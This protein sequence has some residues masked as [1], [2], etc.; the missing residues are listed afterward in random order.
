MSQMREAARSLDELIA[1]PIEPENQGLAITQLEG[2]L[3]FCDVSF[4]YPQSDRPA[5]DHISF[6]A[7]PGS[8]LAFVGPSGCGK[9]TILS[10][11]LGF[12]RPTS[13]RILLDGQDLTTLKL[14]DYR[15]QIGV[16]TQDTLLL[17][18]T[19][20]ENVAYGLPDVSDD[21]IVEALKQAE[22]YDFVCQLPEGLQ[23]KIGDE[24]QKLSGGQK[25]RLAL[26]RA[27]LRN[28]KILIL[29]EATSAIDV[30]IEERLQDT[31][32]RVMRGRTTFIVSHRAPSIIHCDTILVLDKGQVTA[33]GKH[34]ELLGSSS[35]YR[36]LAGYFQNTL[37]NA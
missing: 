24:G 26:A 16:V 37:S 19:I 1:L 15:S 7:K 4:Q 30:A 34:W 6:V 10:L 25:Q 18:G 22:A 12:F 32:Q 17:A 28:P 36:Q 27:L 29:D 8:P 11:I 20:W 31:L 2:C 14:T 3:E 9:T 23:T 5:I 33:R 21:E 35:F 13:G